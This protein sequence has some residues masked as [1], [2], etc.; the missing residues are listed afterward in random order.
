MRGNYKSFKGTNVTVVE[1]MH[2]FI[3][4]ILYV[5]QPVRRGRSNNL[6]AETINRSRGQM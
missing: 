4:Y 2:Q 1:G 5:V 3:M 6:C